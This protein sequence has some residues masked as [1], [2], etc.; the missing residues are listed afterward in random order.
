MRDGSVQADHFYQPAA[1]MAKRRS[2]TV[3]M[4]IDGESIDI[5]NTPLTPQHM[6]EILHLEKSYGSALDIIR[7][8]VESPATYWE[9]AGMSEESI[10]RSLENAQKLWDKFG[11]KRPVFLDS[12]FQKYLPQA[13]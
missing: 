11:R 1:A 4:T 2:N 12:A 6:S 3:R 13:A 5:A 8:Y 10:C 9:E 7:R